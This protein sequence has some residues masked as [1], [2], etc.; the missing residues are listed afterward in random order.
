MRWEDDFSLLVTERPVAH[1]PVFVFIC[2][3]QLSKNVWQWPLGA[4]LLT[5][6]VA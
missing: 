3:S 4:M 5:V 2:K 6:P 1:V